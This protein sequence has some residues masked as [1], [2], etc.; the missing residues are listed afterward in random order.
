MHLL[1]KNILDYSQ[2]VVPGGNF[3]ILHIE[4]H[5]IIHFNVS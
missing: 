3:M 4:G 5:S 2:I 1:H